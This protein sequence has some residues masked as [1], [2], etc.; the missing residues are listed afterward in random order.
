MSSVTRLT[1]ELPAH[2][3]QDIGVRLST[4]LEE[5]F[6]MAPYEARMPEAG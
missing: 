3:Q 1:R 6:R 5:Y 4:Y 2:R